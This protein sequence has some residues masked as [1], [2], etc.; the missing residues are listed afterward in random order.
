MI[1]LGNVFLVLVI[2]YMS[3]ATVLTIAD[4]KKKNKTK[5]KNVRKEN[6]IDLS[7]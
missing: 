5:P 6:I 3:M 7:E 1:I 2:I 4:C